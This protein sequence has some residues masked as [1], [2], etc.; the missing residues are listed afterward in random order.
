MLLRIRHT[1]IIPCL[2]FEVED[3]DDVDNCRD[4]WGVFVNILSNEIFKD[5]CEPLI[6][7]LKKASGFLDVSKHVFLTQSTDSRKMVIRKR[8]WLRWLIR[9]LLS[10]CLE[11]KEW[12]KVLEGCR[13]T[14]TLIM[15]KAIIE[16][17]LLSTL[18]EQYIALLWGK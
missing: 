6:D 12:P 11:R 1:L 5:T 14:L 3:C 17:N 18:T 16:P 15:K 7:F 4:T 2:L 8:F 13:E 9:R 10:L